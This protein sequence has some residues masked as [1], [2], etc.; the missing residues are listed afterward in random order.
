MQRSIFFDIDGTLLPFDHATWPADTEEAVRFLSRQGH[1]L[2]IAT[3]R[4]FQNLPDFVHDSG[5]FSGFV[6]MNGQFVYAD[7][8]ELFAKEL[9]S[10]IVERVRDAAKFH[11]LPLLYATPDELVLTASTPA[12][13]VWERYVGWDALVRKNPRHRISSDVP[14]RVL[15]IMLFGPDYLDALIEREV[16]D[17]RVH[18]WHP[19]FLDVSGQGV[20]KAT[21][22]E[23]IARAHRLDTASIVAVGDAENDREMIA[24]AAIGVAMQ[25]ADD[26]TRA[27][28]DIVVAESDGGG[29]AELARRLHPQSADLTLAGSE[30]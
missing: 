2:Y 30:R 26:T 25:N 15:Q 16:P 29:I 3:G 4:S 8:R 20:S 17:A 27:L 10:D 13:A 23:C 22:I 7:G 21:G 9:P 14:E 1:R 24:Y 19:D 12:T 28:A 6:C 11:K 18:R 5:L